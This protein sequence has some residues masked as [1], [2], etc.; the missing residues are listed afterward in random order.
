MAY[1]NAHKHRNINTFMN[2]IVLLHISLLN[3]EY[4]LYDPEG[5]E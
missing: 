2:S 1:S 4:I 3:L 5:E